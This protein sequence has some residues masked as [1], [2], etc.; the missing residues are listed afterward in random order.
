MSCLV[1]IVI[2]NWNG[3]RFLLRCLAATCQSA[4]AAGCSSEIIVVDDA[5]TDGSADIVEKQF[6]AVRLVRNDVNLGFGATVN[7]GAACAEGNLLVLLNN[8]LVPK[9]P[10]ISE[11]VEPLAADSRLFGV[12]AKTIDWGTENPNHVNMAAVWQD[13]DFEL[14]HADNA[15]PAPTMFLQ[16]GSCAVRLD[17]Y[18]RLGG[19]CPLF[20]PGYWE[21]YDVSYLAL[22]AGWRNLYNPRAMAY[23]FGQGS[24]TRA[25]DIDYIGILRHRNRFLFVWCNVTDRDLLASHLKRL[26]RLAAGG[27]ARHGEP[28]TR[29]RGLVRAVHAAGAAARERARRSQFIVRPDREI[30]AEFASHGQC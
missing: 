24:M 27:M 26:P 3:I 1:S 8:D 10:M 29:L 11:L 20:R 6:P 13:G 23:H 19:F 14:R 17:E 9:E 18:R 28:R 21:D 5:S 2:P 15:A 25:Y 16:G 7:R 12:S 30:L 22:K 4:Q